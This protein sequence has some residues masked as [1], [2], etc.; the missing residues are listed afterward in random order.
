MPLAFHANVH[1]TTQRDTQ[2]HIILK[3]INQEENNKNWLKVMDV[4]V[5]SYNPNTWEVEA[6]DIGQQGYTVRPFLNKTE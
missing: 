6:G 3:K 2:I 5:Y 1:I 4:E